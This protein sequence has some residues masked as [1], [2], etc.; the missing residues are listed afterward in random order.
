MLLYA[1]VAYP[2]YNY[3]S[4]GLIPADFLRGKRNSTVSKTSDQKQYVKGF[5]RMDDQF[6]MPRKYQRI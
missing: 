2:F 4:A 5:K 6:I 1:R 3:I